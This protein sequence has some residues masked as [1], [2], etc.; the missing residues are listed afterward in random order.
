MMRPRCW[1]SGPLRMIDRPSS[2]TPYVPIKQPAI[3]EHTYAKPASAFTLRRN[4]S[5]C[6]HEDSPLREPAT[7]GP[8]ILVLDAQ[9]ARV[10]DWLQRSV[11]LTKCMALVG[12]VRYFRIRGSVPIIF[13]PRPTLRFVLLPSCV[14][15]MDSDQRMARSRATLT[16]T[17]AT[18]EAA[19]QAS[20]E[21]QQHGKE[22]SCGHTRD[23]GE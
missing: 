23:E 15:A 14:R 1:C 11:G 18:P 7:W 22:E 2:P 4:H 8:L 12:T 17:G 10:T 6:W 21:P 19:C 9:H 20:C 5:C 16:R 13:P 3:V